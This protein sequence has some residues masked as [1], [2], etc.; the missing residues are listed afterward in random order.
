M[1]VYTR[2]AEDPTGVNPDNLVS[3]EQI[4]LSDKVIRVAVPR[5]GP[6]FTESLSVYDGLTQRKLIKG[7]EYRIPTIARDATLK[8]GLEVADAILIENSAV[9]SQVTVSYQAVGGLFQ[10]NVDN[11]ASMYEAWANDDRKVDW[12]TGIMGKPSEFPPSPHPH[13]LSDLAGFE[14]INYQLERIAQAI[15]LGNSPAFQAILNALESRFASLAEMDAGLPIQKAVT[16]EGLLA[17]LNQYNFNAVKFK[18]AATVI[19]D[20]GTLWWT[21]E[22]S[23]VPDQVTWY[24]TIQHI[25]TNNED[26]VSNSGVVNVA[27]GVGRFMLQ[28]TRSGVKEEIETFRVQLHRNSPTGQVI[29]TSQVI[30]SAEHQA[31]HSDRIID[32]LKTQRILSPQLTLTPKTFSVARSYA[33]ATFN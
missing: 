32:A 27:R 18:P 6:F 29:A 31:H 23:N 8:F 28:A 9:A 24:W 13:W 3:E 2:Y 4:S 15:M 7:T 5:Y 26:F 21:I 10:N 22:A 25:D 17:V 14:T 33:N 1:T 20:G 12:L 30:T 19:R 16:L 11:L